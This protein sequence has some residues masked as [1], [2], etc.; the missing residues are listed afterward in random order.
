[1]RN[2]CKFSYFFF[3]INNEIIKKNTFKYGDLN[4]E[5]IKFYISED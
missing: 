4:A 2:E 1:L 3:Q 5:M